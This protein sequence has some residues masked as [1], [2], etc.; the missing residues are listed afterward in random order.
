MARKILLNKWSYLQSKRT[1]L[2]YGNCTA[3]YLLVKQMTISLGLRL[4]LATFSA[5]LDANQT[6]IVYKLH[7]VWNKWGRKP[8]VAVG[9]G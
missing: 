2:K 5:L 1:K 3:S 9:L 8:S 4:S 6:K 7:H